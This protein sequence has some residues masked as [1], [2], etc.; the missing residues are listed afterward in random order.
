MAALVDLIAIVLLNVYAAV[1]IVLRAAVYRVR[2]YRPMLVNIALS[3]LPV[4]GAL[5][6]IAGLLLLAPVVEVLAAGLHEGAVVLVWIY[7]VV[8]TVLWVLFFPNAIYLITELNFSHRQESDPVPL[9]FDIVQTLTLTLSGIANAIAG[10]AIV[11]TGFVLLAD[12]NGHSTGA[13][14]FSWVFAGVVI[15][16]GA[17]GVYLGRYLRFNSWDVRHPASLAH[18]LITH[19]R[20]PGRALEAGG[21]VLSHAV[22]VALVYVPIYVIFYRAL[23]S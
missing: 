21:F 16:L 7:L 11:Q 5:V 1:L 4:V 8:A 19:L 15:V 12:P 3:F 13:P 6:G 23:F 14:G 20:E 22:L 2:L 10:L 9:W 18:K 17:L